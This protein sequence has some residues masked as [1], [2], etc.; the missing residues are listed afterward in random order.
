MRFWSFPVLLQKNPL[1]PYGKIFHRGVIHSLMKM[2]SSVPRVGIWVEEFFNKK[3]PEAKGLVLKL[4]HG[5]G[6][7]N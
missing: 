4:G 7:M 2:Y 1:P 3:L 5:W 6:D